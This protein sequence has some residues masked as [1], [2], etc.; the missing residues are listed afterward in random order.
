MRAWG[1]RRLVAAVSSIGLTA[2]LLAGGLVTASPAAALPTENFISQWTTSFSN[3]QVGLPLVNGGA[4]N[5][6][7][8]WGDGNS[9]VVTSWDDPDASHG[10][11]NPGTYNVTISSNIP[12]E[13][14]AVG[15]LIGWNFGAN[16]VYKYSI[17]GISQW[18]N[19]VLGDSVTATDTGGYFTGASNLVITATDSP[20]LKADTTTN[21][22]QAF[23]D[24]TALTQVGD[25]DTSN[26]TNM[27]EMFR[28]ATLFNQDIGDWDTGNV[29]NMEGMFRQASAFNQDIGNWNTSS[30]INMRRMFLQ[31]SSFNSALGGW[32]TSSVITMASMFQ[33]ASAFN[34]DISFDDD[35]D[36]WDT[37]EVVTMSSM[38]AGA[39]AFNQDIGDWDTGKVSDMPSMFNDAAAFDQDLGG[40]YVASLTNAANMFDNSG[41][42]TTNY[43]ALLEGWAAQAQTLPGVNNDVPLGAEGVKYSPG[44]PTD[45]RGVLTE[46]P[47]QWIITD[48][49]QVPPP[50][51]MASPDPVEF[52]DQVIN[53]TSDPEAV[54]ITNQGPSDLVIEAGGVSVE[55]DD[56]SMFAISDDQCSGVTLAENE[57]CAVAVTFTPTS[58]GAKESYLQV[59]S[60]GPNTPDLVALNGTGVEPGFSAAPDPVEFGDVVVGETAGPEVVTV[61]NTGS[62]TLTFNAGDD[63]DG[64]GVSLGGPSVSQA[65]ITAETCNG[66]S[67]A[68]GQTCTVSV[69]F[70]PESVG[71]KD[72]IR[73]TFLSNA[74]SSPAEV[75]LSAT[76][77]EE[78]GFVAS[79]NP[80]NFGDQ[81]VDETSGTHTVTVTN[82]GG[83]DLVIFGDGVAIFGGDSDQF[84]VIGGSCVS[85]TNVTVPIGGTCTVEVTF[86]PTSTGAKAAD[87][88]VNVETIESPQTVSLTGTGKTPSPPP[89]PPPVVKKTQQFSK[90]ARP[91]KRVKWRGVTLLNKRGA[92]TAEGRPLRAKVRVLGARGEVRC[93]RVKRG[94]KRSL[95]VRT[96]GKCTL[97][98]R[99]TYIA[100]GSKTYKSFKSVKTYRVRR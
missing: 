14:L 89:P 6:S 47:N 43:D 8:D 53:T 26:V 30:V 75:F 81:A 94:A 22:S 29:E 34:Q 11:V 49:G 76:G 93:L 15:D 68:P 57:T 55:Y 100:P 39:T 42:S 46:P 92:T 73:L 37:G 52:E 99:V 79:P 9:G 3:D 12:G 31:A 77:V 1:F 41:L 4:Y 5:F 35:A 69:T 56:A 95:K 13:D 80:V 7:V 59:L 51:F 91:P 82:D 25:W 20:Y 71:L 54:T 50:I 84:A 33:Q 72:Q 85:G 44:A 87:L 83:S 74:P 64:A 17:T 32:N 2:G 98:L 88:T 58:E 86:T 24:C 66:A 23:W 90:G 67:L 45:A 28:G 27:S 40:W 96:Y 38:F 21:M 16:G 19:L 18:G 70:T 65:A 61:T 63:P 62:G 97:R 78:P 48:G 36:T 10:Y 60:N